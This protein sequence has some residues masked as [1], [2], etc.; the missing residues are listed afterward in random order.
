[1]ILSRLD[2]KAFGRFTDVSIDLSAGPRHF[3]LI[4]GPNE[5]GKSTSLRAITSLLFGM[6]QAAEDC[7]A[8]RT[9]QVR[10]GGLL[11]DPASGASLECIRRRGR[12]ATLR[13][14]ADK[15]PIDETQLE[16]MLGGI[17][18]ETFLARF[19]LSYESLVEGGAAILK[20]NGDLGQILFAAGAGVGR[21]REIQ[22]ELDQAACQLFLPRGSK[23]TINSGLKQLEEDRKALRESQVPTAD[24]ATLRDRVQSKQRDAESLDQALRECVVSLARMQRWKQAQPLLPSWRS[25][26]EAFAKVADAPALDEAFTERRRQIAADREKADSR[27]K[28]LETRLNE[29][30]ARLRSLGSDPVVTS[31]ELEIQAA[32]QQ[33]S[34]REKSEQDRLDLIRSRR[35][36]D[37][38]IA[39]LLSQLSA[40]TAAGMQVDSTEAIENALA[41]LRVTDTLR[42]RI[43]ELAAAHAGLI[44]RRNDASDRIETT[45]RR[46]AD[47]TQE[48]ESLGTVGDPALLANVIESTGNPESEM[49]ALQSSRHNCESLR[50]RCELMLQRLEG[51]EG[52]LEQAIR[53]ALPSDSSVRDLAESLRCALHDV[54]HQES[55]LDGLEQDRD[56]VQQKL[57]EAQADR[58]LPT[59]AELQSARRQR[60][61]VADHLADGVRA[62][63][64]SISDVEELR[65]QIRV[66]DQLAD[67]MREHSEQVHRRE[68]LSSQLQVLDTKIRQ[69]KECVASAHASFESA[70]SDWVAAWRSCRISAGQPEQMQ[71]WLANH[72][73]LC[74]LMGQLESEEKRLEQTQARI[75][76][77]TA[78][79]RKALDSVHCDQTVRVA[80]THQTGTV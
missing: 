20:G 46:L 39:G 52:D 21:L 42:A 7:F 27:Q 28:D 36:L 25:A 37:E 3:H 73:K 45:K 32:F 59:L 58:R 34:A 70:K 54:T 17:N 38:E 47:V 80:S 24:F 12:K 1:M 75:H 69:A 53:L 78:R 62:G 31:H 26:N 44:S 41:K 55:L 14:A 40:E 56:S 33:I 77:A 66:A 9:D 29:L 72:E 57:L 51:F 43:R 8:H 64:T 79:L 11:I 19:G 5:S 6:P 67:T 22:A 49:D 65:E 71:Q 48:L 15:E 61:R 63:E 13:D 68:A 2:L 30:S 50:R 4:Y 60:D 76:R 16:S 23:A 74:D 18:R 35:G 10:V